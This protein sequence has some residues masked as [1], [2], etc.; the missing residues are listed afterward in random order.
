M[1]CTDVHFSSGIYNKAFYLM[2]T[3]SGSSTRKA[4]EVFA[5]AN[6]DYWTKTTTFADGAAGV[7]D[8]AKDLG[9]PDAIVVDAFS[10]VGINL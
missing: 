6:M 8:A 7:R 10:Q 1:M 5:K 4:F 3:A 2:A 9:F